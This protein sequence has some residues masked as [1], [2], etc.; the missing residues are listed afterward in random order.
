MSKHVSVVLMLGA[1]IMLLVSV[2]MASAGNM[3]GSCDQ[4]RD[5]LCVRDRTCDNCTCSAAAPENAECGCEACEYLYQ[6]RW[7]YNFSY[8]GE[9]GPHMACNGNW[10]WGNSSASYTDVA[11]TQSSTEWPCSSIC[12]ACECCEWTFLYGETDAEPPHLSCVGQD[13]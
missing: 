7:S 9:D 13:E 3:I 11:C 10:A 2:A 1:A 12:D 5:R 6:H 4:D 8:A